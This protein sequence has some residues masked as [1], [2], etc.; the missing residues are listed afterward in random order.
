VRRRKLTIANGAGIVHGRGY[1]LGRQ[2]LIALE[3]AEPV[4][5]EAVM[6]LPS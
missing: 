4:E 6:P 2:Y 3:P 1:D 5:R